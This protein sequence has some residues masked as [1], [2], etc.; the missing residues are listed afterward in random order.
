MVS[1]RLQVG[2][3]GG[4]GKDRPPRKFTGVWGVPNPLPLCHGCYWG[5]K[6][7][8]VGQGYYCISSDITL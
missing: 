7:V 4:K 1:I 6:G 2:C 5:L 3:S 8:G